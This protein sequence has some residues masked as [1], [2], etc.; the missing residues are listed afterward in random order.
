DRGEPW[1]HCRDEPKSP[2]LRTQQLDL[3]RQRP[4]LLA[5]SP[6]VPQV[7]QYIVRIIYDTLYFCQNGDFG[8]NTQPSG[9]QLAFGTEECVT[10]SRTHVRR[11][12]VTESRNCFYSAYRR[13][14]SRRHIVE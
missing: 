3:S 6:T 4:S 8:Q 2:D 7:T 5:A 12:G 9:G 10:I 14:H 1:K 13:C 11:S